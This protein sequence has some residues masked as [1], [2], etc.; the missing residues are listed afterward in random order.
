MKK[1]NP[2]ISYRLIVVVSLFLIVGTS[3]AIHF[4][5]DIQRAEWIVR[6]GLARSI[7]YII[8]CILAAS[9][10]GFLF[11]IL[12][13]SGTYE[14]DV[15]GGKLKLGGA[16]VGFA[17]VL[18]GGYVFRPLEDFSVIIYVHGE[19]GR[20]DL[21]LKSKGVV[22]LDVKGRRSEAIDAKGQVHFSGLSSSY[23]EKEVVVSLEGVDFEPINSSVS[24]SE[25]VYLAVRPMTCI[26]S[27][28]VQDED[29]NPISNAKVTLDRV[30][31]H[32]DE[33]GYFVATLSSDLAMKSELSMVVEAYGF[34]VWRGR[35]IPR[36]KS[37]VVQL[38][39]NL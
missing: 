12:P 14:G 39:R 9:V 19:K 20:N 37:P 30:T 25:E 10:A 8:L 15:L 5:Q 38:S 35:L 13:S 22:L 28:T 26:V 36:G 4:F 33:S 32:S 29:G 2:R 1:S 18:V 3:I 24:L 17:L 23:R 21:V 6:L 16:V 11:G 7:Y 34:S 31:L 27:G